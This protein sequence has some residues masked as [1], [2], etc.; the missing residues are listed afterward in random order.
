ML[1]DGNMNLYLIGYRCT[2]KTTVGRSLAERLGWPLTD[3][4]GMIVDA[5]A[6]MSIDHM[7]A[8][9]GWSFFRQREYEVLS[10][11]SA[12]DRQVVAT[13]GGI[14]LDERNRLAMKTTGKVVWLTA[15]ETCIRTRML[16]DASTGDN[17]PTLT[18]RGLLE[19]IETVL[20]ERTPL[21]ESAADLVIATDRVG[22]E[23]ICDRIVEALGI[24][25]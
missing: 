12:G 8:S 21:Y 6:G 7:V 10:R 9:Y 3:T 11:V 13:G 19:E 5:A 4:D 15:S 1:F 20:A 24:E 2:G 16:A 22:I 17:R 23:E 14:V 18:G 25:A